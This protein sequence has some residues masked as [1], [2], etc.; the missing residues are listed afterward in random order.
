MILFSERDGIEKLDLEKFKAVSDFNLV[1][2]N[3]GP[4]GMHV[5][6]R[7]KKR[8]IASFPWWDHADADIYKMTAEN[9]LL[10]TVARPYSDREQ[11]WEIK[12]WVSGDYVYVL[13][14]TGEDVENDSDLRKYECH[15]R[16]A[17]SAYC[18]EWEKLIKQTR[19]ARLSFTSLEEALPHWQ[20]TKSLS[21]GVR[22]LTTFP[23]EICSLINLEYLN[24]Y[25]NKITSLPEEIGALRNLRWLILDF[26]PL[27]ALPR[28]IGRLKKLEWLHMADSRL[29]VLPDELIHLK[30]L[31]SLSFAASRIPPEDLSRFYKLRPDLARKG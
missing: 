17:K 16:V 20:T 21:L 13:E 18:A 26:N 3:S 29:T 4:F 31:S 25:L 23:I 14:G 7:N 5:K 11:S 12:I 6:M 10:G 24:L 27:S 15:F 30:K 9:M 22:G 2:H 19:A 1:L 28:T 8:R